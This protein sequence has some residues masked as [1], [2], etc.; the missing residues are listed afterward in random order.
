M[1]AWQDIGPES[2]LDRYAVK[3]QRKYAPNGIIETRLLVRDLLSG[4]PLIPSNYRRL[5]VMS[6]VSFVVPGTPTAKGRAQP[7]RSGNMRTPEKTIRAERQVETIAERAMNG[8]EPLFGPIRISLSFIFDVPSGW[9]KQQRSDALSGLMPHISKPDIDNIEKM[10]LDGMNGVVYYDDSQVSE[11]FKRK[12]YGSGNRIEVI[13]DRIECPLNHP[14]LTALRERIS[15]GHYATKVGE[16]RRRRPKITAPEPSFI[17][18]R[19][20]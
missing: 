18:R 15:S 7:D 16:T 6:R 12:R 19:I 11:V 5:V 9:N 3:A 2:Y 10:V 13:V 1:S 4:S 8:L 20:K 14:A 17:G